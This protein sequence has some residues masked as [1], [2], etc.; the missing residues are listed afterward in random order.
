MFLPEP[1]LLPPE[2]ELLV[3]ETRPCVLSNGKVWGPGKELFQN[4]EAKCATRRKVDTLSTNT[5]S[6]TTK[7]QD[8]P[9]SPL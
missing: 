5:T 1:F 3:D 9:T 2:G 6:A 8:L 4:K 7:T